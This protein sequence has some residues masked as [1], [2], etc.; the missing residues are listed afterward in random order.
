MICIETKE[1]FDSVAA[2]VRRY[3]VN[4]AN[5]IL[6]CQNHQRIIDGKHFWYLEDFNKATEIVIPPPKTKPQKRKV[7][8]LETGELFETIRQAAKWLGMVHGTVSRACRKHM[9][10][11][12]YHFRYLE[13]YKESETVN[14]TYKEPIK[15][16]SIVCVE[17]GE[18]FSSMRQAERSKDINHRLISQACK[19][20]SKTAG[21]CHWKFVDEIQK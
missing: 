5:L 2:A 11:G 1:I 12:G 21:G 6:A 4:R 7:V 10:A 3:K 16:R 15:G 14:L 20:S 13:E 8:C 18:I 9:R 19:D 17:T